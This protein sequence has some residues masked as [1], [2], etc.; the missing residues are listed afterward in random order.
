MAEETIRYTIQIDDSD[1]A[2]QLQTIR[3]QI[4]QTVSDAF[5][6]SSTDQLVSPALQTAQINNLSAVTP[7]SSI[8]GVTPD[9]TQIISSA[10]DIAN[11]AFSVP[12][13]PT[14]MRQ[15]LNNM[16]AG[17]S[18]FYQDVSAGIQIAQQGIK[19]SINNSTFLGSLG[20]GYDYTSPIP[21]TD[22]MEANKE[23]LREK[24]YRTLK[25]HPLGAVSLGLFGASIAV[26]PLAPL[27][28]A[29]GI[30]DLALSPLVDEVEKQNQM[31]EGLQTMARMSHIPLSR[32]DASNIVKSMTSKA[33]S[34]QG[35]LKII[36]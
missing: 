29:A 30:A 3:Q 32:S 23:S 26:P 1:I 13:D 7:I 10:N 12:Q 35:M 6:F 9:L 20:F 5:N 27:A 4:N 24:V 25:E 8:A 34:F 31:I 28:I 33:Y 17:I 2:Q 18:N 11:T 22:Y 15:I 19:D 16:S 21:I 14:Y 36:V